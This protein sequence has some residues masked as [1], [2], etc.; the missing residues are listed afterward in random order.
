M[1]HTA[2][3]P[4][5]LVRGDAAAFAQAAALLV[6]FN[7]EYDDPAPPVDELAAHLARLVHDRDAA[8]L[9]V[10]DPP[11]GVAVLRFRTS[12]W[13]PVVEA[14]LA[15]FYVRPEDRGRGI[16]SG[17]LDAVVDHA[18]SR[19]VV[20]LDLATS[21]DDEA[22]R[23]VYESRGFDCHETPGTP[24]RSLFYELELGAAG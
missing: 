6:A 12:T 21:E 13:E 7:A 16:G 10:G 17:L 18:R 24:A 11:L 4:V 9:T 22:A 3:H 1:S 23:H 19:H 2:E 5:F 8:V 20:R 14:T 15:E